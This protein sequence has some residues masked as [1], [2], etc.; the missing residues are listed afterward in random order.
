M[1]SKKEKYPLYYYFFGYIYNRA[2]LHK[3]KKRRH[4]FCITEKFYRSFSFYR[5]L[6]D[7]TSYISL[8]K[9]VEIYKKIVN[10]KFNKL[11]TIDTN[12]IRSDSKNNSVNNKFLSL[13]SSKFKNK[14]SSKKGL[15]AI[16]I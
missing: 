15:Q 10:D 5:L 7:I 11:N 3:N 16:M 9:D 14:L 4:F 1:R 13:D 12:S 8:C 2:D 6:I